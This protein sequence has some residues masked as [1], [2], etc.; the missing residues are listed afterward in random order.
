M[1]GLFSRGRAKSTTTKRSAAKGSAAKDAAAAE[2]EPT[3]PA[4]GTPASTSTQEPASGPAVDHLEGGPYDAADAPD[5]ERIDLGGLQVPAVPGLELRMEIDKRTQ[6]VTAVNLILDGS[7]MQVQAFAAPKS[8]GLWKNVRASL[9]DS[10]VNQGGTAE[11]R[12][13]PFGA[14]LNTRLPL[15]R[16]DGRT[17][18]RPARFIG[19]DGPRWLVRAIVSGPA[20]GEPEQ[21][22]RFETLL[23][24]IVVVRG[25]GAMAPQELIPLHLPG[26]RATAA[27]ETAPGPLDPLARGPEI[28]EVG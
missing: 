17:G 12:P 3:S 4:P 7:S 15:S 6:A 19:V 10:V 26:A 1:M 2:D 9:R 16:A 21:A 11:T 22:R 8:T 18:Y 14:E 25:A 20:L 23:S 27:A 24:R 13:G 28:T 5:E